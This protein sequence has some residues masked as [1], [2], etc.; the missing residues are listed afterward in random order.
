PKMSGESMYVK[1]NVG[2]ALYYTTTQTL[3]KQ[4]TMFK[5]MFSSKME[6][7]TDMM[8]CAVGAI[9]LLSNFASALFFK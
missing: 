4:D 8:V 6:V 9:I 5:A 3:T 2:G 1:L 7:L